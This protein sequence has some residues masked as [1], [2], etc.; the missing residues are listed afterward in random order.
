VAPG[1]LAQDEKSLA[2]RL[3]LNR[4]DATLTDEDQIDAP[5]KTV[6]PRCSSRGFGPPACLTK[7]QGAQDQYGTGR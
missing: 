3:V 5:V 7:P 4:D 2:L 1:G 6:W